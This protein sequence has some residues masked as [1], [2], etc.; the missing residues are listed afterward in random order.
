MKSAIFSVWMWLIVTFSYC[1]TLT[2]NLKF[3]KPT[4]EELTMTTYPKDADAEAVILCRKVNIFYEYM[5]MG[6]R[7]YQQV[8]TRIKVLKPE[9][10]E[11][12]NISIPYTFN[13]TNNDIY[14]D[15]VSKINASAF[16]MENGKMVETKMKS[17]LVFRERINEDDM[18]VKFAVPQVK[19]GTVFEY[20]YTIQTDNIYHIPTWYAQT[21]IPTFYTQ[22]DVLLPEMFNYS[23]EVT[24]E[25]PIESTQKSENQ[26]FMLSNG[27][28]V[29]SNSKHYTFVGREL[30][31]LKDE[32]YV[33]CVNDYLSKVTFDL[34]SVHI[35]N[36]FESFNTTWERINA[37]LLEHEEFGQK[38]SSSTPLK[39]EMAALKL[40]DMEGAEQKVMAIYQLLMNRVKWNGEYSLFGKG[41]RA[42]LK[43]GTGSNADINFILINMLNSAGFKAFPIVVRTR[44][45]GRLPLTHPSVSKLITFVV[46]VEFDGKVHV[47]DASAKL[48]YLD[49][50]SP[51]LMVERGRSV[52]KGGG[53]W[54]D[55]TPMCQ[56]KET[57]RL[58][59]TITADGKATGERVHKSTGECSYYFKTE[60]ARLT[61][62]VS[63]KEKRANDLN[64]TIQ[65]LRVEG[66]DSCSPEVIETIQFEKEIQTAG[67]MIYV[68]PFVFPIY[69]ENP[70]KQEKRILPIEKPWFV[71]EDFKVSLTI[72]DGYEIE[73]VPKNLHVQTPDGKV[74]C[75]MLFMANGNIVNAIYKYHCNAIF[76]QAEEYESLRELFEHI[77]AKNNEMVVL[78]KQ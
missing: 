31:G 3:G 54:I 36:K 27:D 46:G 30:A 2:E 38:L 71:A 45:K 18:V 17:N 66:I 14:K 69:K 29:R 33:W 60:Y 49:V 13:T 40:E 34:N 22:C 68:S 5:N 67:N 72:P 35:G 19:V 73:S 62:S 51:H 11:W 55:L 64:A 78:K 53:D 74:S 26:N 65:D 70:F 56:G 12:A 7:V 63:V 77:L 48:G 44:D 52:V 32:N 1:Q 28:V 25:A 16:N 50:V 9:G 39:D 58:A 41:N 23:V 37:L 43:D 76:F 59:A 4:Q 21:E 42:V 20:E 15:V 75:Q 47:L 10:M 24:G 6:F 8:Q 61:D 57:I